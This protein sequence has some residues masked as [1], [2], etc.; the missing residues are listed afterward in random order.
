MRAMARVLTLAEAVDELAAVAVRVLAGHVEKRLGDGERGAQLVGG[1]GGEP[2]L[3]GD[4]RFEP[5]E[6]GVEGVGEVLQLVSGSGEREAVAPAALGDLPRRCRHRAK[7]A[8]TRP[9]T[10]QPTAIETAA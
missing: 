9:A 3:L 7:G 2:L 8:S 4:V 5:R 10:S 1:V 6:D